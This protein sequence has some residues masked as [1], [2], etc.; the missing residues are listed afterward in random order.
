MNIW[1][2]IINQELNLK[3]IGLNLCF[4][5]KKKTIQICKEEIVNIHELNWVGPSPSF[6]WQKK[7]KCFCDPKYYFTIN[8]NLNTGPP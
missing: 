1:L 3:I 5:V 6:S 4:L 2:A 8:S 7:K